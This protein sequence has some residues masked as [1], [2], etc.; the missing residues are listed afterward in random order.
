MFI[1]PE[2]QA[3]I[4]K[5]V[6]KAYI[7]ATLTYISKHTLKIDTA[8]RHKEQANNADSIA[9]F[10]DKVEKA[11]ENPLKKRWQKIEK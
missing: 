7:Q 2:L 3:T 5:S 10:K 6:Q 1:D 8:L 11:L 4:N 9:S